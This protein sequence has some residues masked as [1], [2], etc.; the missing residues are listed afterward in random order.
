MQSCPNC[1]TD[2]LEGV[3]FCQHCGVAL[4]PVPISTRQIN[5]QGDRV[6]TGT[7]PADNVVMLHIEG[8]EIPH[9]VQL[10]DVMVLGRFGEPSAEKSITYFDLTPYHAEEKGVSRRHARLTRNAANQSLT[11]S[12]LNS[13]N[14]SHLN[15]EAVPPSVELPVRDGDE[16]LLGRLKLYIY[17]R[18]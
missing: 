1:H 2:N 3:V 7:L 5:R 11:F 8:E 16:I 6:G 12:D 13:T 4:V 10:H 18:Y 15:G 14:G 17:F 9:T